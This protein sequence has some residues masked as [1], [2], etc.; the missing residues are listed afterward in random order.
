ME[1]DKREVETLALMLCLCSNL[2]PMQIRLGQYICTPPV[3]PT[4]LSILTLYAIWHRRKIKWQHIKYW[5]RHVGKVSNWPNPF[6][7]GHTDRPLNDDSWL[8]KQGTWSQRFVNLF[9]MRCVSLRHD[10][11]LLICVRGAYDRVTMTSS[12]RFG[13]VLT[14]FIESRVCIFLS[15]WGPAVVA[16]NATNSSISI[17]PTRSGPGPPPL[18]DSKE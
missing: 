8:P 17:Y 16:K 10:V 5:T 18:K 12:S 2:I 11:M 13:N 14:V 6:L 4:F 1:A 7:L 3:V 9:R 15:H